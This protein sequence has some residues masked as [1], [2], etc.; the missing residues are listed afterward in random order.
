MFLILNRDIRLLV[1]AGTKLLVFLIFE[2]QLLNLDIEF[3]TLF[4]SRIHLFSVQQTLSLL[5]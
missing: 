3:L 2:S 4:F 1:A 5:E